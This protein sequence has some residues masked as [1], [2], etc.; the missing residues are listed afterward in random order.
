MT[1]VELHTIAEV[2]DMTAMHKLSANAE[3][4]LTRQIVAG[5][6]RARRIGRQW[7]MTTADVEHMLDRLS[8]TETRTAEPEVAERTV[9]V[10]STA[11]MRRRLVVAK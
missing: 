10:P 7:A 2:C 9:G 6:F 8:N 3:Q 1:A 5:K 11:S 4:W